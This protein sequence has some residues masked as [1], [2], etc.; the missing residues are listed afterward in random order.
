VAEVEGGAVR[1]PAS[2][3]TS[4]E[5]D[6]WCPVPATVGAQPSVTEGAGGTDGT[7]GGGG[8]GGT[9]GAGAGGG[10]GGAAGGVA[11]LLVPFA[12]DVA[13]AADRPVA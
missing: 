6:T 13:G 10:G 12:A 4:W 9:R 2:R 11:T 1:T 5:P 8:V 3:I 7:A